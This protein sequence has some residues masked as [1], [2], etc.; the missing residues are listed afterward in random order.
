MV[1]YYSVDHR[2]NFCSF[3]RTVIRYQRLFPKTNEEIEHALAYEASGSRMVNGKQIRNKL[4]KCC[5]RIWEKDK[6]EKEVRA[7]FDTLNDFFE[8]MKKLLKEQK[9]RCAISDIFMLGRTERKHH[10]FGMSVDAI[11]PSKGH[12][13]ENLR[14][15]CWF[16]NPI[17]KDND[18]KRR[19]KND[20]QSIWTPGSFQR[21]LGE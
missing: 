1:G 18:K 12:V 10:P 6:D 19:D 2:E 20:G 17:N 9:C 8:A 3:L 15:V 14:I 4:Y 11:K 21:Y 13:K 16:M 5:R 7:S